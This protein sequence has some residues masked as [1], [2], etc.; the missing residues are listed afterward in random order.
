MNNI[1]T[2]EQPVSK[3]DILYGCQHDCI[4]CEARAKLPFD[5]KINVELGE[6]PVVRTEQLK[7]KFK[8]RSGYIIF[9]SSHDIHPDN[10]EDSITV[11]KNMLK[12]GNKVVIATKAHLQC[13]QRICE[14]LREYKDLITF[15]FTIGTY[16][17]RE[18]KYWEFFA[19]DFQERFK[20]LKH[21]FKSGYRTSVAI[22]PILYSDTETLIEKVSPFVTD[23]III[24][25]MRN[26]IRCTKY[27]EV[28]DH[29]LEGKT[30][31]LTHPLLLKNLYEKLKT[32]P[33]I[34]WRVS[35]LNNV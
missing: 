6:K 28:Y 11:L 21:A 2:Q 3:V 15:R 35:I 26:G 10:L 31:G 17:N 12:P 1:K 33:L 16:H 32:N 18:L 34:K 29:L 14:E 4:Y 9:P 27:N 25:A 13:V 23:C 19:P 24:G 8:K 7:K 20:S 5:K 30:Y 22:E